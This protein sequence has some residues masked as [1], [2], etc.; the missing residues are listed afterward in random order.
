MKFDIVVLYKQLVQK[1]K[2]IQDQDNIIFSAPSFKSTSHKLKLVNIIQSNMADSSRKNADPE[3]IHKFN[4]EVNAITTLNNDVFLGNTEDREEVLKSLAP[5]IPFVHTMDDLTDKYLPN[6]YGFIM[7]GSE[8][9]KILSSN[10]AIVCE[11]KLTGKKAIGLAYPFLNLGEIVVDEYF[12]IGNE[13][14]HFYSEKESFMGKILQ[15]DNDNILDSEEDEHARIDNLLQMM[16]TRSIT[17]LHIYLANEYSYEITGRVTSQKESISKGTPI[18]ISV[19]NKLVEGLITRAQ[20]DPFTKRAETRGLIKYKVTTSNGTKVDRT[21]RLHIFDQSFPPVTGSSVSIRRL[22]TFAEL[23]R[24]SLDSMGY[25]KE[26]RG[27]IE[28]VLTYAVSGI[29]VVSGATNSGKTTFLYK[30]VELL[31]ARDKRV[32]TIENP[33]EISVPGLIQIDLKKTEDAIDKL[34]VTITKAIGY[35]MSHDPDVGLI[36]EVRYDDEIRSLISLALK[37]HLAATTMHSND[38]KSC[39]VTLMEAIGDTQAIG[40]Y[41]LFVNQKLVDLKC[42]ACNGKV[43]NIIDEEN[44]CKSCGGRGVKGKMALPEVLYFRRQLTSDDNVLDFD[45]LVKKG[46]AEYYPRMHFAQHWHKKNLLTDLVWEE[47]KTEA[48]V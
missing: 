15:E 39:L 11:N 18:N 33:I 45:T 46:I 47:I 44:A 30:L 29:V 38:V 24:M 19:I 3:L 40:T 2:N 34:Q 35:L 9:S 25:I 8:K 16:E 42:Q 31:L 37:G 13:I 20:Q 17:D 12:F 32:I 41:R 21:F 4:Q 27:I 22:M 14:T 48:G 10:L 7:D 5:N 6:D 36:S 1:I 26:L 23:T 28:H 43:Q